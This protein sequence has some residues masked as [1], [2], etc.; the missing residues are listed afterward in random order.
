MQ[1]LIKGQQEEVMGTDNSNM[2]IEKRENIVKTCMK[3]N[4]KQKKTLNKKTMGKNYFKIEENMKRM[5]IINQIKKSTQ[6]N[7]L[8]NDSLIIQ[9]WGDKMNS[10][11]RRMI[12]KNKKE[13]KIRSL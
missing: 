12:D 1:I 3:G 8:T 13:F 2:E 11:I 7:S 5:S 10:I 6:S 4:S 9:I